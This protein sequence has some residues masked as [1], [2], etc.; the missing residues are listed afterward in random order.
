MFARQFYASKIVCINC[1]YRKI[2][3]FSYNRTI[4]FYKASKTLVQAFNS[5]EIKIGDYLTYKPSSIKTASIDA[6]KSGYSEEQ[7]YKTNMD[8]TWRV[9]G[10]NKD[11]TELL[12]TSGSP[13]RRDGNDP[14]LHLVGVE[15]YYFSDEILDNICSIYHNS[16]FASETRSM[17][18]EDIN[19]VLGLTV[20]E[21][22]NKMYKTNDPSKTALPFTSYFGTSYEYQSTDYAIENYLKKVFQNDPEIQKLETKHVGETIPGSLYMY[23]HT[24]A[25]IIEQDS[26]LY[27]VLFDS[28][29]STNASKSYWLAKSKG[30]QTMNPFAS[31]GNGVVYNG[32]VSKG[33]GATFVTVGQINEMGLAVRPI[34]SLKNT[35][36][37]DDIQVTTGSEAT[38]NEVPIVKQ[39]GNIDKGKVE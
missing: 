31:Y 29:T 14:Y 11:G 34:I 10:L 4:V 13:I 7:T 19:F 3:D 35:V 27:N 39:K 21:D 5:G 12:I 36:T 38:W 37:V 32:M 6:T 17:T 2:F 20:D 15:G 25:D 33:A 24:T 28:T 8:T 9:L 26:A 30:V 23:M 1:C 22:S 16:E 18:I